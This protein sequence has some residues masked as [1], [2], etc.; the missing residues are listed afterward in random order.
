MEVAENYERL[1]LFHNEVSHIIKISDF[2]LISKTFC[3][4]SRQV[5]SLKDTIDNLCRM[6]LVRKNGFLKIRG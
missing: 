5:N 2:C 3:Q 4:V 6:L 1:S